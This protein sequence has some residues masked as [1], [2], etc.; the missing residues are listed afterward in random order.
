MINIDALKG[1][2][3][4]KDYSNQAYHPEDEEDF[5]VKVPQEDRLIDEAPGLD[6]DREF[7]A[8]M[9]NYGEEDN[10]PDS[11]REM[12]CQSAGIS[13]KKCFNK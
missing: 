4:V 11:D 3:K 10:L 5:E 9:Y 6:D 8:D 13:R 7:A 1:K 2:V 12:N